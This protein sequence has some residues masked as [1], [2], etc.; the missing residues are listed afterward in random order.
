M[1][2]VSHNFHDPRTLWTTKNGFKGKPGS[3]N[4][5]PNKITFSYIFIHLQ[6][7][8]YNT[9][10]TYIHIQHMYKNNLQ[11]CFIHIQQM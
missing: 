3:K 1:G 5:F 8:K 7:I 10:F 11:H 2:G 4:G 6:E 9:F